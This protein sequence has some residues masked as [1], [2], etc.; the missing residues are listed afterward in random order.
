MKGVSRYKIARYKKACA[1]LSERSHQ[2]CTWIGSSPRIFCLVCYIFNSNLQTCCRLF[3]DLRLTCFCA[4]AR[5]R[6]RPALG[7]LSGFSGCSRGC[8]T[9]W[10]GGFRHEQNHFLEAQ[11]EHAE[12]LRRCA[13]HVDDAVVAERPAVSDADIYVAAIN[14]AAHPN[15]GAKR[16]CSVRSREGMHVVAFTA[17][18]TPALKI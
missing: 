11:A 16:Q 9:D 13:A 15:H 14:E 5:F 18:C 10:Q 3:A 4:S 2:Y 6:P 17:G 1:A 12:F 7:L 8:F